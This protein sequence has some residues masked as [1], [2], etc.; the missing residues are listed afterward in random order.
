[1]KKI[2]VLMMC[3]S[4]L[5]GCSGFQ[6][7]EDSVEFSNRKLNCEPY[8][9]PRPLNLK[10]IEPLNQGSYWEFSHQDYV[11]LRNWVIDLERYLEDVRALWVYVRTCIDDFNS[12]VENLQRNNDET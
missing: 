6:A 12:S 1:M 8:P 10:P 11:I 9:Y 5:A 4:L 2:L 7:R 3:G